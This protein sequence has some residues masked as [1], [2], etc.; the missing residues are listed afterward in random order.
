[1]SALELASRATSEHPVRWRAIE[2]A[3]FEDHPEIVAAL[4]SVPRVSS[5]NR[6][7]LLALPLI[8]LIGIVYAAPVWGFTTLIGD[9]FGRADPDPFVVVPTAGVI[10]AVGLLFLLINFGIWLA[11]GRTRSGGSEGQAGIAA[12]LGILST[13]IAAVMAQRASVPAWGLWILPIVASAVVGVLFY[14]LLLQARRREPKTSI[15]QVPDG[16]AVDT[17]PEFIAT[18]QGRIRTLDP[19]EQAAIR[20]DIHAAISDLEARGVV[21]VREAALARGA[22]LGEL[23]ARMTQG[24]AAASASSARPA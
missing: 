14:V 1:M 3:A 13:V 8:L 23:A 5:G 11:R 10:F 22:E 2:T 18:V 4:R 21:T 7:F 12:V 19:V 15:A 17:S 9:R 24:P 16:P 6:G 20:R